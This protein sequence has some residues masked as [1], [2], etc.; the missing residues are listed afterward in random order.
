M[1]APDQKA[2]R[3]A[4]I[5]ASGFFRCGRHFPQAGVVVAVDD[6]T[7]MQWRRI[8]D[9]PNLKITPTDEV[10]AEDAEARRDAIWGV[11]QLLR[12]EDFQKDGKPKLDAIND[13]LG[14]AVE[15]KVAAPERDAIWAEMLG[16]GFKRPEPE[17]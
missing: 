8:M 15:G 1:F 17:A 14:D 9:D 16:D 7:D 12:P 3:V 4:A 13:A 5:A 10:P 11:I 2:V 6:L